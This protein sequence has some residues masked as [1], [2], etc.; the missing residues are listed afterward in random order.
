MK[1]G[2]IIGA[3]LATYLTLHYP[4]EMSSALNKVTAIV[5][6]GYSAIDNK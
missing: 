3:V 5:S 2:I 4:Q 1:F 6:D